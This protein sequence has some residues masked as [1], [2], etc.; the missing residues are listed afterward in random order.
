MKVLGT[1]NY[2]ADPTLNSEALTP[3]H[4]SASSDPTVTDDEDSEFI[5][6]HIWLREDT[7]EVWDCD[8]A[9]SGAAVWTSRSRVSRVAET[10][11]ARTLG[12]TDVNKLIECTNAAATTITIPLNTTT[13]M[14]LGC[15]IAIKRGATGGAVTI[16]PAASVTLES[17]GAL[18]DIADV[19]GVVV[20]WQGELNTWT[21]TGN[22]G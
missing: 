12:L 4:Y 16:A 1:D 2:T 8:D 17:E 18:Y 3:I 9:S 13:A 14:P 11:T 15:T 7:K 21:L 20:L 6:G 10:T 19:K 5:K 22:R